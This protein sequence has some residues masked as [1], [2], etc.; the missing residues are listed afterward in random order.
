ME[1]GQA[2]TNN[3]A[4]PMSALR[5]SAI[6]AKKAKLT[7]LQLQVLDFARTVINQGGKVVTGFSLC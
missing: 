5:Q 6:G 3:V 7:A 1:S 2:R 4:A